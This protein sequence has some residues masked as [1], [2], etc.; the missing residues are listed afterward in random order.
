MSERLMGDLCLTSV[1]KRPSHRLP[2]LKVDTDV[3]SEGHPNTV[4]D[5]KAPPVHRENNARTNHKFLV[6]P[7]SLHIGFNNKDEL[8]S[9]KN[10][11]F[12]KIRFAPL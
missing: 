4:F 3:V 8:Q 9:F 6:G 11:N 1:T 10:C 12:F 2:L 5:F 7:K